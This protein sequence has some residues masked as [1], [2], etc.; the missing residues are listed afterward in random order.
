MICE[1]CGV[2]IELDKHGNYVSKYRAGSYEITER[3][4]D[5]LT[6]TVTPREHKPSKSSIINA[7]LKEI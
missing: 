3:T 6:F 5:W 4:C 1:N 7:I 2:K